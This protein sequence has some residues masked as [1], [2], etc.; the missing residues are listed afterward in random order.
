[1]NGRWPQFRPAATIDEPPGAG[2][3]NDEGVLRP[4]LVLVIGGTKGV[5]T[6]HLLCEF[7]IP[8][9]TG[10]GRLFGHCVIARPLRVLVL[11]EEGGEVEEFRRKSMTL[12]ALHLRRSA[13]ADDYRASFASMV[14]P[15]V[16]FRR[17]VRIPASAVHAF[18]ESHTSTCSPSAA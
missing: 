12:E 9:A 1:M 2:A 13:L 7:A 11:D 5:V 18:A 3:W 14:L 8:G 10:S 16:R 17:T 4:A 15:S 6:T